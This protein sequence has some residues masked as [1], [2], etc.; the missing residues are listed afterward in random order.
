MSNSARAAQHQLRTRFVSRAGSEPSASEAS[1]SGRTARTG[2]RLRTQCDSAAGTASRQRT[3][4]TWTIDDDEDEDRW[5]NMSRPSRSNTLVM[6]DMDD[7]D[8]SF[9][10]RR[11]HEIDQLERGNYTFEYYT[12]DMYYHDGF[13]LAIRHSDFPAQE[14]LGSSMMEDS[15]RELPSQ[16]V[17]SPFAYDNVSNSHAYRA[18]RG[19]GPDAKRQRPGVANEFSTGES[20]MEEL[21][22]RAS[23]EPPHVT[24]SIGDECGD[25]VEGDEMAAVQLSSTP[26][27]ST[28]ET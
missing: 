20:N 9:L 18:S 15:Q 8:K 6:P 3:T 23:P 7:K 13:E 12:G 19:E 1:S 10:R 21:T 27:R 16:S 17:V 24:A 25:H 26:E 5:T 28:N 4:R 2:K 11:V 22:S 14:G